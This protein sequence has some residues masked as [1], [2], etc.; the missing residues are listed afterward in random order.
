[1]I[2]I[3][4]D[5]EI[6]NTSTERLLNEIKEALDTA[7]TSGSDIDKKIA[8]YFGSI[9]GIQHGYLALVNYINTHK[10]RIVAYGIGQLMSAG[11]HIFA[12]LECEKQILGDVF[13]LLHL[14]SIEI[15]LRDLL[16]SEAT[17]SVYAD[18]VKNNKKRY[19]LPFEFCD[20]SDKQ[21]KILLRGGDVILDPDK[22]REI[23]KKNES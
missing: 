9:G 3:Y 18:Y 6:T 19:L 20:L 7:H 11:F 13:G 22:M 16:D 1:M 17:G 2:P 21:K 12:E 5:E 4:F 14:P 8:L 23:F 10:A 15:D